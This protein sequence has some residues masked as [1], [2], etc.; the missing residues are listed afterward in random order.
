MKPKISMLAGQVSAIL[1][2][3]AGATVSSQ[4]QRW[5]KSVPPLPRRSREGEVGRGPAGLAPEGK[6]RISGAARGLWRLN[7][8]AHD[9]THRPSPYP[10]PLWAAPRG[11]GG[12]WR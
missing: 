9:F 5:P 12:D 11:R 4:R 6:A 10:L 8:V 1:L 3:L 2:P 7:P